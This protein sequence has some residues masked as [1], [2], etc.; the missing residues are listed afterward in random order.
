M[1]M[2]RFI[3]SQLQKRKLVDKI[4]LYIAQNIVNYVN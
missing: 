2:F 1:F 4:N 3:L